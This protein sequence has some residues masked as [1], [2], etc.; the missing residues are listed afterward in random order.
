MWPLRT[1]NFW[2]FAGILRCDQYGKYF[3]AVNRWGRGLSFEP[4]GDPIRLLWLMDDADSV[5]TTASSVLVACKPDIIVFEPRWC[6]CVRGTCVPWLLDDLFLRASEE[7][8]VIDF[9]ISIHERFHD[10]S[11]YFN[12]HEIWQRIL[13]SIPL[14]QEN[15]WLRLN[16]KF[17]PS[18][19]EAEL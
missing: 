7:W 19:S 4:L 18:W 17:I 10:H 2:G 16:A 11:N 9:C 15:M 1:S 8:W 14:L 5:H 6:C 3:S 13:S 12:G